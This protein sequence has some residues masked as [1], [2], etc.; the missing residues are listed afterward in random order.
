[1]RIIASVNYRTVQYKKVLENTNEES[2]NQ[3]QFDSLVNEAAKKTSGGWILFLRIIFLLFILLVI[4]S[5]TIRFG[6]KLGLPISTS[7]NIGLIVVVLILFFFAYRAMKKRRK[8]IIEL[9]YELDDQ[10]KYLYDSLV[11]AY[12]LMVSADKVWNIGSTSEI[13]EWKTSAGATSSL[14]TESLVFGFGFPSFIESNM[15]PPYFDFG[16]SQIYFLPEKILIKHNGEYLIKGYSAIKVRSDVSKCREYGSIPKDAQIMGE[17]WL[18]VN[19]NG[20]RDKRFKNNK[21]IPICRYEK[22]YLKVNGFNIGIMLSKYGLGQ[23]FTNILPKYAVRKVIVSQKVLKEDS[24]N[25]FSNDYG[26]SESKIYENYT[27]TSISLDDLNMITRLF[28]LLMGADGDIHAK[29]KVVLA[30]YLEKYWKAEYG[31]LGEFITGM[32]DKLIAY[33]ADDATN[34]AK[35]LKENSKPLAEKLTDYQKHELL[36]TMKGIMEADNN[37]ARVEQGLYRFFKRVFS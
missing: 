36:E 30:S 37:I 18:K 20:T 24:V 3:S 5:Q 8:N 26:T 11:D 9:V 29:E 33:Y 12:N 35:E 21:K 31:D 27:N 23:K 22:I 32:I 1:M 25:M 6:Q 13:S 16:N 15:Q 2:L 19:R 34:L 7:G 14:E 4:W 10:S 17:T 28:I